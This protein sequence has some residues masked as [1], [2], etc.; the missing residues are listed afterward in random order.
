MTTLGAL[1]KFIADGQPPDFLNLEYDN[2][3]KR[4]IVLAWSRGNSVRLSYES[5]AMYIQTLMRFL[6]FL[7][8]NRMESCLW[9]LPSISGGLAPYLIYGKQLDGVP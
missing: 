8:P 9:A 4:S 2:K 1:N 5:N 7:I 6:S 3:G